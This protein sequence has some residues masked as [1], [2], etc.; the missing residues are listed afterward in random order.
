MALW[1][2]ISCEYWCCK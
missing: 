1:Q 2:R